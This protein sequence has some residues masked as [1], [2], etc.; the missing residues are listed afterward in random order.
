MAS[1]WL[2]NGRCSQEESAVESGGNRV[3]CRHSGVRLS[4]THSRLRLRRTT[5]GNNHAGNDPPPTQAGAAATV[6]GHRREGIGVGAGCRFGGCDRCSR[7]AIESALGRFSLEW[8]RPVV[9]SAVGGGDHGGSVVLAA[10]GL[11]GSGAC[12]GPA[13]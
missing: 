11:A 1:C 12:G 2:T 4:L 13:L 10:C 6:G 7:V 8:F 3:G 5:N 9:G